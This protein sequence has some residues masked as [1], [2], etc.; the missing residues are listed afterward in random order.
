MVARLS[1]P[2]GAD[3]SALF[4]QLGERR[5]WPVIAKKANTEPFY[6]TN[7]AL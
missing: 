3:T 7:L 1:L 6:E 5:A 4:D 2:I